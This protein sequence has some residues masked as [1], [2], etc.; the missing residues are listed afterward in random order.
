MEGK[1]L[2]IAALE[3]QVLLSGQMSQKFSEFFRKK[4]KTGDCSQ[5]EEHASLDAIITSRGEVLQPQPPPAGTLKC[6][7]T[8]EP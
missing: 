6:L 7:I 4:Q 5:P 1:D 8:T 2:R 3:A